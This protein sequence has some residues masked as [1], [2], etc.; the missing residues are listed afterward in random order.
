MSKVSLFDVGENASTN[1]SVYT[2]KINIPQYQPTGE[3]PTLLSL[4]DNK[5]YKTLISNIDASN[6]SDDEKDFLRLAATRHIVF[7]Y[8]KIAEYYCH[9]TAEMQNLM[10]ESALVIIDI[11]DA[12]RNGFVEL[13]K[14]ITE[15]AK[16]S[17]EERV[18]KGL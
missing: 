4:Y 6:V 7:D 9:A 13:D 8:S 12:I 16:A 11:N 3:M 2:T 1:E 10:E 17:W 14:Q 15:L 5:K 18:R